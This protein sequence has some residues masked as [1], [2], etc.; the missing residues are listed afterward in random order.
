MSKSSPSL[1]ARAQGAFFGG[2]TWLVRVL[3]A[4]AGLKLMAGLGPLGAFLL[5]QRRRTAEG[6][7]A[8]ALGLP[9]GGP[10]CRRIARGSC[11]TMARGIFE[12]WWI[13]GIEARHPGR[14]AIDVTG[15]E[16]VRRARAEGRGVLLVAS[17]FGS[18]L[19]PGR[20]LS[21]EGA[22]VHALSRPRGNASIE[23]RYQ[24]GP[25]RF[26]AGNVGMEGGAGQ[27][28]RWLRDGEV[29]IVLVDQRASRRHGVV[30]PFLG[31]PA[32]HH[33]TAGQL[34]VRSGAALIPMYCMHDPAGPRYR[35]ELEAPL[36]VSPD[37]SR[38]E[39][40]TDLTRRLSESLSAR[41][42]AHPEL[43]MWFHDRWRGE[44]PEA[45]EAP[46]RSVATVGQGTTGR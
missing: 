2:F 19:L 1:T 6:R 15:I 39:A 5:G 8:Q 7:I 21:Q 17:H 26:L 11:R 30:L 25:L 32:R 28:M 34:A 41:V 10:E 44:V 14:V 18:F 43:Y 38:E 16:H 46:A 22:V 42:R 20:A 23:A 36:E 9:P 29:V 24:A 40:A 33:N 4:G 37:L 3:P 12:S 13:D 35:V 45:D 31:L 27:L